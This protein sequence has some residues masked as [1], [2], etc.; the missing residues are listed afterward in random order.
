MIKVSDIVASV[1]A[2]A[3]VTHVFGVTGGA[4]LHLIESVQKHKELSFVATHHEQNAGMAADALSRTGH[5]LGCAIVTSGPGATNLITAIAGCFYDSI[6][7]IFIAGQVSTS[8]QRGSLK[9]RQIGFQETPVSE[10]VKLIVKDVL[11]IEKSNL[12]SLRYLIKSGI[13]TAQSD[14]PGPVYIEIPDDL[15]RMSI[16]DISL[17]KKRSRRHQI[18]NSDP[19]LDFTEFH[20]LVKNSTRPVIVLGHGINVSK[21]RKLMKDF[22]Q[23]TNWPILTTWAVK[24]LMPWDQDNNLG[25]FGTHGERVANLVVQNS[26]LVVAF[27]SRLDTKATGS[28][29]STF[30]PGAKKIIIDVDQSELGKFE[31]WDLKIDLK[32]HI[33]LSCSQNEK[34]LS[35]ILQNPCSQSWLDAIE[36]VKTTIDEKK[37][38]ESNFN[39]NPY[40]FIDELSRI[41][42]KESSVFLDTGCT[43]AW[44]MQSWKIQD[45]QRLYHDFN[46][47]AMGWSIPA[48]FACAQTNQSRNT[49]ALCGDGSLMMAMQEISSFRK[50]KNPIKLFVLNNNGYSMIKQ[51]Q[52]QW[53]NS[54]YFGSSGDSDLIFPNLEMLARSFDISYHKIQNE[55]VL[56]ESLSEVIAADTSV[57]C[58]VLIDSN[59]RVIPQTKFGNTIEFMEPSYDPS[60]LQYCINLL[61]AP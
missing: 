6:P 35:M 32:V 39:V 48:A 52:E 38:R 20:R 17:A 3:G 26:D 59:S 8:R 49:I 54:E 2:E 1:L 60:I 14:R 5:S 19:A 58:E 24:D 18:S 50:L 27:G 53:F 29:I 16:Q 42:P 43:V 13:E 7:A 41:C 9:V 33:D 23:K 55:S 15:Q 12:N 31:N 57:L 56:K 10:M 37:F 36:R 34:L 11:K 4:S 25:T 30:A 51:T 45:G 28:P 21:T 40:N 47:T 22:S 46:N 61:R 44:A